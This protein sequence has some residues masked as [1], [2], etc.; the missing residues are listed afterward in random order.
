M[1][2]NRL[3]N[4]V[5]YTDHVRG[6][7]DDYVVQPARFF[8]MMAVRAM[9]YRANHRDR[10]MREFYCDAILFDLDGV[11][12][13]STAVVER[14]WRQWA[15]RNQI[16]IADVM[17][18]SHGR[19]A[20]EIIQ[21]VAP[22]LNSLAE[23]AY[24][25]A[26]EA[27]DTDGLSVYDGAYQLLTTLPSSHW[28]VATSGTRDVASARLTHAGL[29]FPGVF[30]TADDVPRGKP[31]PDPYLQAAAG[32][33]IPA[34]RCIVIEDAPAGVTA[35]LAAGAQVIA[36]ATTHEPAQLTHATA[37]IHKLSDLYVT[38]NNGAG[39][40]RIQVPF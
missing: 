8:A 19:R 24:L 13:D 36:V 10:V 33:G 11:L 2:Q 6:R 34:Q 22:G 39:R 3:D 25:A 30:V 32:L 18:I 29:P 20:I 37:V 16:N 17:A 40:L 4:K 38:I 27:A 14:Q 7:D 9:P 5:C 21:A 35:G 28:A 15:A 23:A 26:A 1:A 31:S 12:V